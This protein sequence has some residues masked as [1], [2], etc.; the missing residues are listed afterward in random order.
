[1]GAFSRKRVK[2]SKLAS[3]VDQLTA[4]L[5]RMKSLFLAIQSETGVVDVGAPAPPATMFKPEEDVLSVAAS[6]TEFADYGVDVVPQDSASH[7]SGMSS[8]RCWVRG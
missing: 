3:T 8:C 6:A 5:N 7:T 4:E 2:E 1:M